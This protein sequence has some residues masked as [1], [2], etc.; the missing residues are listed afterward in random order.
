MLTTARKHNVSFA[1]IKLDSSMKEA[2]PIWYHLGASKKLR[3]LNNTRVSDCLR[4]NHDVRLVADLLPLARRECYN[5]ARAMS[6]D[7]V[8]EECACDLCRSDS[9]RGCKNPMNCCKAAAFLLAQVQPKWHP[10]LVSPKDG[11]TLTR[12]RKE[13]NI[14][15][16]DEAQGDITFDPS[17]TSR[18]HVTEAFR[19]F[20]DPNVHDEPPAIRARRGRIVEDEAV[21]AYV[22][23]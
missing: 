5:I 3:S 19:A 16:L 13:Q 18:G 4:D 22:V 11:L 17:L 23:G 20:V 7:F 9:T 14:K 1:A 21:T 15:A 2:L 12:R 6:N 10:D 8:P